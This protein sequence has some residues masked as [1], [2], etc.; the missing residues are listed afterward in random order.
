M[1]APRFKIEVFLGFE[2]RHDA[3]VVQPL[4]EVLP[5]LLLLFLLLLPGRREVDGNSVSGLGPLH[6]HS[7][8]GW[9]WHVNGFLGMATIQT[10]HCRLR[11]GLG[12]VKRARKSGVRKWL[13]HRRRG[14]VHT[15]AQTK[16]TL[17]R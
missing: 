1:A 3:L 9:F 11:K 8:G 5:E 6:V 17:K 14:H 16:R 15:G 13:L 10:C 7:G 12:S 2:P 4:L